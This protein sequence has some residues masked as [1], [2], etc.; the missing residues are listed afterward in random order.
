MGTCFLSRV[1]NLG[2]RCFLC[3]LLAAPT[4]ALR[5]GSIP[6]QTSGGITHIKT[7]LI[8]TCQE[9]KCKGSW[10]LDADADEAQWEKVEYQNS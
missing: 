10:A 9:L 7:P 6:L 4:G 3:S 5:H 2:P 1:Q 8:I